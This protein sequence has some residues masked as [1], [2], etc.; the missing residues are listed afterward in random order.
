MKINR[1]HIK[2][3]VD[4]FGFEKIKTDVYELKI[5]DYTIQIYRFKSFKGWT[6]NIKMFGAYG[7]R[8]INSVI[9]HPNDVLMRIAEFRIDEALSNQKEVYKKKIREILR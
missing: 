9:E 4:A 3:I 6:W 5:A 2:K 7:W 8:E 1:G